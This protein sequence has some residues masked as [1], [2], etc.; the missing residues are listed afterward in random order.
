M[1]IAVYGTLRHGQGNN[2]RLLG[3]PMVWAGWLHGYSMVTL[4][5]FP[6]AYSDDSGA[7]WVEVYECDAE[8]VASCNRLE[9]YDPDAATHSFY[10]R[11]TVTT[12][13]GDAELY[14]MERIKDEERYVN[15]KISSGD[16][17]NRMGPART[18]YGQATEASVVNTESSL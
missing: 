1:K 3:S 14:V 9:G 18:P 7:I 5:G 15:S 2:P 8:A 4:G 11:T 10:D 6:A 16:W 17:C 13:V 12:T